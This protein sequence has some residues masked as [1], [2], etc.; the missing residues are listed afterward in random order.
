MWSS[1]RARSEDKTGR[2]AEALHLR[3]VAAHLYCS[4]TL[5]APIACFRSAE[6]CFAASSALESPFATRPV[7]FWMAVVILLRFG[8]GGRNF[9]F[10]SD[11]V[12]S[13]RYCC[14]LNSGTSAES[15]RATGCGSSILILA[16]VSLLFQVLMNSQARSLFL[17][18]AVMYQQVP[19]PP[20]VN[21]GPPFSVGCKMYPT[22]FCVPAWSLEAQPP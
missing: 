17:D 6:Y 7:A 19:R 15:L 16:T 1:A 5:S 18:F 14:A 20:I 12:E 22:F 2:G 8:S 10:S 13:T 4:M 11:L 21:D 9:A 3:S